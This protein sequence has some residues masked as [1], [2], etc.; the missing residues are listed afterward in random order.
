MH[1]VIVFIERGCSH[2]SF[3]NATI[4]QSFASLL[5]RKLFFVVRFVIY[6]D[7]CS[8]FNGFRR[9]QNTAH[10]SGKHFTVFTSTIRQISTSNTV[11][12]YHYVWGLMYCIQSNALYNKIVQASRTRPD[13]SLNQGLK[14]FFHKNGGLNKWNNELT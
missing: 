2:G 10:S 5:Y 9:M 13:D 6:F 8:Q 12:K 3:R 1:I 7:F 11:K 14:L 4:G